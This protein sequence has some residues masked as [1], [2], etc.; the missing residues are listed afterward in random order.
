[1]TIGKFIVC[2]LMVLIVVFTLLWI[3]YTAFILVLGPIGDPDGQYSYHVLI[4]ALVG[5]V[6][7]FMC[8]F[9]FLFVLVIMLVLAVDFSSSL[10]QKEKKEAAFMKS[11]TQM[12]SVLFNVSQKKFD[13]TNL[14]C[15]LYYCDAILELFPSY[16]NPN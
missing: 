8:S 9:Y 16:W 15:I 4:R 3:I 10:Q 14:Y 12:L 6:T 1:M 11:T 13:I 5:A 2:L 7:L